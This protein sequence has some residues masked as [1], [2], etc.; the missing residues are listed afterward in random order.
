MLRPEW[1][2]LPLFL[3]VGA[4]YVAIVPVGW[5]SDEPAHLFRA[6]EIATGQILPEVRTGNDGRPSAGGEV[7]DELVET[8]SLTGVLKGVVLDP[9]VTAAVVQ[10]D[11]ALGSA[12]YSPVGYV[13][14]RNTAIYS[15]VAY[16]PQIPA[17]WIG[18]VLGLSF[19]AVAILGRI[20]GLLAVAAAGFFAIRLTP[21][22]KWAVATLGL[23]PATV[24]QS[25]AFGADAAVLALA[26]LTVA[27]VLRMATGPRPPTVRH[28]VVFVVLAA[29]LAL[30]KIPYA[31]LAVLAL[32]VPMRRGWPGPV[33]RRWVAAVVAVVASLV[34]ALLWSVATSS[35]NISLNPA[36]DLRA[37][38]SYVL[39]D[40]VAFL[41]VLY[42][43]FF[44]ELDGNLYSSMF[45]NQ[46]WLTAPLPT[47][48]VLVAAAALTLSVVT[49]DPRELRLRGPV[50]AGA[51]GSL[52]PVPTRVL[53][54]LVAVGVAAVVA[55]AVYVGFSD[56]R[57]VVVW[58]L[59]GRYLLPSLLLLMLSVAGN[60]LRRPVFARGLLLASVV[61]VSLGGMITLYL[62]LY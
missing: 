60:R 3:L 7:P 12:S 18:Q 14:F 27:W 48:W 37:Q 59:Q 26:L 8:L 15:P 61:L 1:V 17:F 47:A 34:P 21:A 2:F 58:G 32:A 46:I 6:E 29:G 30:T 40:P 9:T 42:R 41:A 38:V 13:D 35:A 43:T 19:S 10:D 16:L 54:G 55:A 56:P 33:S 57:A 5:N 25:A 36:A 20:L 62:R 51:S 45:G 4:F 24:S 52:L 23:L 31:G 49:A 44:T 50:R 28:W 53:M 11:S 22:G 39:G